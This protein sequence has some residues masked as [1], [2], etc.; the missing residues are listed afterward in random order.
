ME[1]T[2]QKLDAASPQA[3]STDF[4]ADN[5]ARLKALFPELVTEGPDGASV[6][7]DVL[8]ALVGERT[9][10]DA[11]ERYGFHWHGKRS[12]RQA[13]L[14]PST[15]TLRPC[16]DDSVAWDDTRHL[17][18]EGDNL[19]VMKL[20]HKSYA[21]KVKLVYID[22]PYNTGSDFVYPDDFSDSIRHYLAMTGQTQGGMK[23]STN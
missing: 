10:G 13:A 8:K 18:I 14:T 7:V 15:G 2:M 9:V 12:A 19:D 5:V 11:D 17:V 1:K 3:M 4:T 6:D 21:G 20:L 16:P 22:P 23:R